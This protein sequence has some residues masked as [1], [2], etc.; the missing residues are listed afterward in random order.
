MGSRGTMMV[1]SRGMMLG[2]CNFVQGL[3]NFVQ[4]LGTNVNCYKHG[5]A[6]SYHRLVL[7]GEHS[8]TIK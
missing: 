2:S 1:G 4:G 7:A 8:S 5:G 3:G 6:G